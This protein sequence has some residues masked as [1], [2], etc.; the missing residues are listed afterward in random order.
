MPEMNGDE[1]PVSRSAHIRD[2]AKFFE[3]A[4]KIYIEAK[5]LKSG[6]DP[7]YFDKSPS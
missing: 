2:E 6:F 7:P 1:Y 5:R 4:E 3:N